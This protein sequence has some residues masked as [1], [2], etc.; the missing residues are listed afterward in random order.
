MKAGTE[1]KSED[2]FREK[3]QP[4]SSYIGLGARTAAGGTPAQP[5]TLAPS[6]YLG[7]G[8]TGT[9]CF[10]MWKLALPPLTLGER[11]SLEMEQAGKDD[12]K[13]S[14]GFWNSGTEEGLCHSRTSVQEWVKS[15]RVCVTVTETRPWWRSLLCLGCPG[16]DFKEHRKV[17]SHFPPLPKI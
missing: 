17:S 13:D 12:G 5:S 2:M 3:D 15:L 1:M 11:R 7:E 4:R 8:L 10:I 6:V 16:L 14:Q 9:S